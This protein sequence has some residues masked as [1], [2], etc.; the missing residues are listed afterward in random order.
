MVSKT[1]R[2]LPRITKPTI[3]RELRIGMCRATE[4][5]VARHFSLVNLGVDLFSGM[6]SNLL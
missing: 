5:M 3:S 4:S 6:A 1:S 2:F